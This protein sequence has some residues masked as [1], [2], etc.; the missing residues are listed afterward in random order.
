MYRYTLM[1]YKYSLTQWDC[2]DQ[3]VTCV[4]LVSSSLAPFSLPE[5]RSWV[6]ENLVWISV[7]FDCPLQ[8]SLTIERSRGWQM[9]RWYP[10]IIFTLR[11]AINLPGSPLVPTIRQEITRWSWLSFLSQGAG[12]NGDA[13]NTRKRHR[14]DIRA[15][16]VC[17]FLIRRLNFLSLSL[18]EETFSPSLY[19]F[20]RQLRASEVSLRVVF[21]DNFHVYFH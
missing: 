2:S 7:T 17:N 20:C 18:G 10:R 6:I 9:Q 11:P 3:S 14:E 8:Q 13:W 15:N 1:K 16:C 19:K 21:S 12:G 5:F 4:K